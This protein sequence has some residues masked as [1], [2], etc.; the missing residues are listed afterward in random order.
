[1]SGASSTKRTLFGI[2]ISFREAEH[3]ARSVARLARDVDEAVVF[4]GDALSHG[5]PEPNAFVGALGREE[6]SKELVADVVGDSGSGV[7]HDDACVLDLRAVGI[8][9]ASPPVRPKA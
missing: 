2:R 5:Q 6:R 9:V 4:L 3:E 1:M 8:V 7:R